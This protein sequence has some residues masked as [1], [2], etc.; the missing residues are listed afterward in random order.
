MYVCCEE[1]IHYLINLIV[2]QNEEVIS[3]CKKIRN[4]WHFS[5]K[6]IEAIEQYRNAFPRLFTKWGEH[7]NY[8]DYFFESDFFPEEAGE[9]RITE[10]KAW[11][12]AQPFWGAPRK[13]CDTDMIEPEVVEE[14]LS[15]TESSVIVSASK[16]FRLLKFISYFIFYRIFNRVLQ[17]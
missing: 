10:V 8:N 15:S 12:A 5:R 2:F 17:F 7:I 4:Q 16:Y 14:V 1:N 6:A 13:S 3:Y 9:V 11:L